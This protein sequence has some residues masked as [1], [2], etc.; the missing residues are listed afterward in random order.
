MSSITS[1]KPIVHATTRPA[2]SRLKR[3]M[4]SA[5]LAASL[6]L[7]LASASS[8][9][10]Q[11][12]RGKPLGSNASD[13][14]AATGQPSWAANGDCAGRLGIAIVGGFATQEGSGTRQLV[15]CND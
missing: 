9:S 11:T 13:F 4:L 1:I 15:N 6:G 12:L 2:L 10:A 14:Q 8:V 3:A 7:T 5:V